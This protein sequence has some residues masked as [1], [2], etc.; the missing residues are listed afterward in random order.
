M[1][2]DLGLPKDKIERFMGICLLL[3]LIGLPLSRFLVSVSGLLI[4]VSFLVLFFT[5]KIQKPSVQAKWA[6]LSF[7]L[8]FFCHVF[9]LV[10]D[11]DNFTHALRDLQIKLPLLLFPV[12]FA[13]G[14]QW[15][16][17]FTKNLL[18]LFVGAC[19]ISSLVTIGIGLS[20]ILLDR[21]MSF[22]QYSPF[23]SHIRLALNVVLALSIMLLK[24][25]LFNGIKRPQLVKI[26]LGFSFLLCLVLLQSVT[27][28]GILFLIAL[29][30]LPRLGYGLVGKV[31]IGMLSLLVIY[32]LGLVINYKVKLDPKPEN[33][34]N[35]TTEN[36]HYVYYDKDEYTMSL[37]WNERSTFPYDSVND[38]GFV[39][40]ATL[41]R[42]LSSKNLP[43]DSSGINALDDRE[44]NAIE[45]GQSN[46]LSKEWW[47]IRSRFEAIRFQYENLQS[48]GNPNGN[49][50]AMRTVYWELALDLIAEKPWLGRGMQNLKTAFKEAYQDYPEPIDQEYR[51]RAHNQWLTFFICFG[52]LGFLLCLFGFLYPANLL[53]NGKALAN[54]YLLILFASFLFE[55]TLETQ[56]GATFAGFWYAWFFLAR[57]RH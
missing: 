39:L 6:L 1:Q 33:L 25:G 57:K 52:V 30:F 44:I 49:S 34:S 41:F 38:M 3:L 35:Y 28:L 8:V 37:A 4:A 54:V 17:S 12:I 55:D 29:F 19:W 36:G 2:I 32:V 16:K 53:R 31:L 22:R 13:F 23:F 5:K 43:K 45:S 9:W 47:P 51:K 11:G 10:M 42:Y 50:V 20:D 48:G 15:S 56:M 40:K 27:G 26:M 24:K 7:L 21:G 18:L 14:P 46:Y